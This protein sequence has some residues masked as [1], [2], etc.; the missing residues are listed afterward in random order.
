MSISRIDRLVRPF[1]P[2]RSLRRA[3]L[4]GML[5]AS[6]VAG[7]SVTHAQ[8]MRCTDPATGKVSYTDGKC[9][10]GSRMDEIEAR[11]SPEDIQAEREQAAQAQERRRERL[12]LDARQRQQDETRQRQEQERQARAQ[13]PQQNG[14]PANSP[15]C[16]QAR[17]NLQSVQDSTGQGMYDEA[18]RLDDAQRKAEQAC[19][20][21]DQWVQAQRD[22]E[23][24]VNYNNGYGPYVVR[25]PHPIH[26][27]V[28]PQPQ[29]KPP[30][31]TNCNVFRCTDAA[32]NVYP[33]RTP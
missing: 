30:V 25:P 33:R 3:L 31:F 26:P 18:A 29:P 16:A 4:C 7:V 22:R 1:E 6:G 5:T 10:S 19:L 9:A 8:V 2:S 20:T 24:N 23:R 11:R 17:R 15:E 12:E 14:G 13:P 32:G 27:P 21:P 28:R